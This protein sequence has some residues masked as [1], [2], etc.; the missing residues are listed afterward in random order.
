MADKTNRGRSLQIGL[1]TGK[2]DLRPQSLTAAPKQTQPDSDKKLIEIEANDEKE[3][4]IWEK[5]LFN[6]IIGKGGFSVVIALCER[7]SKAMVAAK[8]VDKQKLSKDTLRLLQEE[9]LLLDSLRH[10]TIIPLLG[11]VESQKRLFVFLEYMKGGDLSRM[12]KERRKSQVFFKE[13]EVHIIMKRLFQALQFI[14]SRGVIHRDVKPGIML[15]N[16]R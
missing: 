8:V 11:V 2:G 9:P 5:Y 15:T 12:I 3:K 6:K 7:S 4:A 1:R 10:P 16:H 13:S 14:H